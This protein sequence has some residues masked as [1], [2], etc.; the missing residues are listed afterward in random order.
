MPGKNWKKKAG[1]DCQILDF[2][3]WSEWQ[4]YC[5][6]NGGA[7]GASTHHLCCDPRRKMKT[8]EIIEA[9]TRLGGFIKMAMVLKGRT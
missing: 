2:R 8:I 4:R 6:A 5:L 3:D 7:M 9:E 1:T